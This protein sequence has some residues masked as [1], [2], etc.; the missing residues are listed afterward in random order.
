MKKVLLSMVATMLLPVAMC[1]ATFSAPQL[2]GVLDKTSRV[3]SLEQRHQSPAKADLAD[4][5][6]IMGHYDT[7]DVTTGGGLGLTSFAGTIPIAVILEPDEISLFQGGKIVAFRVGL[8][9]STPVTRVFVAPI[10]N[11]T[12]GDFTEWT[13]NVSD[14]GWNVIELEN[15]Y[16]INLSSDAGLMVGFDYKQTTS[17]YPISAVDAGEIY[18]SYC[19]LTYNGS[20]TWY[21]VGLSSYGNLSVQCIVE[22]DNYPEYLIMTKDLYCNRYVKSG[23]DLEFEFDARNFGTK[24]LEDYSFAVAV[25]DMKVATIVGTTILNSSWQTFESSVS[26]YGYEMGAHTLS[27]WP[28]EMNGSKITDSDTLTSEFV[29]YEAS[30]PRQKHLVEQATSNSCTYCPLGTGLLEKLTDLR[31]DIV[32]VAI[33]GTMN[34][35]YPDPYKTTQCD[36]LN[37][38][39]GLTGWPSAAFDRMNGWSGEDGILGS[40]GYYEQYQA[41]VA[42]SLS[43]YL[44]EVAQAMPTFATINITSDF[45]NSTRVANIK[46]DGEIP[47]DFF[48][49]M[50]ED[51]CLSV[52]LVEDSLVSKQLNMGSWVAKYVHNGVFRQALPGVVGESISNLTNDEVNG[53]NFEYSLTIPEDWDVNHMSVAA[54]ICRPLSTMEYNDMF[55]NNAEIARLGHSSGINEVLS[56]GNEEVVPVAYYDIM[57]REHSSLQPGLNIVKMSNGTAKKLIVK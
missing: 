5:Q 18:D 49:M 12:I 27:V 6:K 51:V 29:I 15:P 4:N 38:V 19:Y 17:N 35:S 24:D 56:D 33:H 39:M 22:S 26:T 16:E 32:W 44:D 25:D 36:T 34:S 7:D 40:I 54:F 48:E 2:H 3:A 28:V 45:D 23:D 55:V 37:S 30:Y 9:A 53:Y 47:S 1:A 57:G 31:D 14:E 8:A 20:T 11:N 46:V 42:E 13:C 41:Q 50:G 21:N 10:E 52:Y 43:E